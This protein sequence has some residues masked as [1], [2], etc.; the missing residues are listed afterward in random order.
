MKHRFPGSYELSHEAVF[1]SK[2]FMQASDI[3]GISQRT[4][5]TFIFQGKE[6]QEHEEI[7]VSMCIIQHKGYLVCELS[8]SNPFPMEG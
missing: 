4:M 3:N 7:Q 2:W 5:K 8:F 1:L 6:K